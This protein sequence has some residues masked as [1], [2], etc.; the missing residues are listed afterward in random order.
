[1]FYWKI[2]QNYNK[3]INILLPK[4]HTKKIGSTIQ[5][6]AEILVLTSFYTE[7]SRNA[8]IKTNSIR[9]Y[10]IFVPS[11]YK[12]N[13]KNAIKEKEVMKIIQTIENKTTK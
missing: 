8:K 3:S 5:G 12:N 11:S 2:N 10:R 1:M 13:H 7:C 4:L 6:V 9:Q